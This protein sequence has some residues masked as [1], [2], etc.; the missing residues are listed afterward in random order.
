MDAVDS[1]CM[2]SQ[3]HTRKLRDWKMIAGI[4]FFLNNKSSKFSTFSYK[5]LLTGKDKQSHAVVIGWC[6]IGHAGNI[7]EK[8]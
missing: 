5:T 7:S 4:T 2:R 8:E 3:T 1:D 6:V